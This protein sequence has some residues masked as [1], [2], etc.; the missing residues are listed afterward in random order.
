MFILLKIGEWKN[1]TNLGVYDTEEEAKVEAVSYFLD[2]I[3]EFYF[4]RKKR[5]LE[6]YKWQGET[7]EYVTNFKT[8]NNWKDRLSLCENM[9]AFKVEFKFDII[10]KYKYFINLISFWA[11][12]SDEVFD[13]ISLDKIENR[14]KFFSKTRCQRESKSVVS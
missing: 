6:D 13:I 10:N 7:G 5:I 3:T 11:T 8:I 2:R 14:M 9:E 12:D 1:V 4:Y